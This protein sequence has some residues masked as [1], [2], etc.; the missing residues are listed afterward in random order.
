MPNV[1]D[2]IIK[3]L[4]QHG[5]EALFGV[6]A[7]FCAPVFDAAARA[8]GF[9]T[10]VTNSDLEAGYAADGYARTRGLAAV[11]VSHGPGTLSIVNAIAAAYVERSPVVVVNGGPSQKNID[12]QNTTGVLFSHSMGRPH[13]D[14]DVFRN[15]T[16]LCGRETNLNSVPQFVDN[17]LKTALIRK[18]PV[19]I[20]FPK[21]LFDAPCPAPTGTIDVTV[22]AGDADA[23]AASIL[24]KLSAAT[25]PVVIVGEEVQ[26]YRVAAQVQA[27]VDR[28]QVRWATTVVGKSVLSEQHPRFLGCFNGDKAPA[29]LKSAIQQAGLVVAL[30]AVF[31]SGH[32]NLMI[33]KAGHT[34]RIWDGAAVIPPAGP[35]PVGLPALVAALDSQSVSATP[36]TY[37]GVATPV[38][39]PPA[40]AA[41]EL[42]YQQVFD[43]VSEP[44]FLDSSFAVIPDTFL[45]IYPAARMKLPAADMFISDG[46][47]ASI[48][49]SVGAAVGVW[50]PGGKRPL[51]LI[52]DGGFQMVGQAVSTMVRYQHNSIIVIIDNSLYGIEQFLLGPGFY[53]NPSQPPL[54]YNVLPDWNFDAF[55]QALGVT[56]V[57]TVNTVAGLRT[58]LAAAKAHT[59][60]P[61]V[62]RALV[63]TRSLPAGI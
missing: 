8:P 44:A 58:A 39:D 57:A 32:A 47:W 62:I 41:V 56:K 23:V 31:G 45:G 50:G 49:H 18:H 54:A 6:P 46:I 61:S 16:V 21:A 28:L 17:A 11:A 20:E 40:A 7:V 52:G 48:G 59:N 4:S 26:R 2:Y 14:L 53:T 1:A 60:G 63:G 55:A 12:D 51:V 36:I 5:V 43:V 24:Q 42:S 22:P 9:R 33:P 25:N 27:V 13:T 29:P 35:R 38:A 34:I 37:T 30:G 10:V 3:R 15:V 19:Y